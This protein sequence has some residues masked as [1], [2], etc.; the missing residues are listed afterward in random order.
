VTTTARVVRVAGPPLSGVTSLVAALRERMPETAFLEADE[1]AAAEP[2]AAVV[3]V[4]SAVAP[5][6]ESDCRRIDVATAQAA[7]V[8]GVLAKVDAHRGWRDVLAADRAALQARAA[9]YR[10]VPWVPVAA[11]PDLGPPELGGLVE[12]L[13]NR[14]CPNGL[15]ESGIGWLRAERAALVS[16]R[17]RA[18]SERALA[19]RGGLARARAA[20]GRFLRQRSMA[21]RAEFRVHAAELP[22]GGAAAVAAE[23]RGQLEGML[24]ELDVLLQAAIEEMAELAEPLELAVSAR[25]TPAGG[26]RLGD[27][28]GASRRGER[29]LTTVLGAGFGLGVA[30]AVSRLLGGLADELAGA[31][32]VVGALAGFA[33]TAWLVTTRAQ[34]AERARL[35]RW[36]TE[37]V[38]TARWHGEETIAGRLLGAE[39]EIA[40]ALSARE[41]AESSALAER[42]EAV[43]AEL[44]ALMRPAPESGTDCR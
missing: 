33:L 5:M 39:L 34:L 35:D 36:V 24:D 29:R 3:V 17:S 44:R 19:L 40:A 42:L 27:P 1:P 13:R 20:A 4:L 31:A 26:P 8:V 25:P 6:T 16:A 15:R 37:V 28:P 7:A 23:L 30:M 9:R 32:L 11:A 43:D 22:R 38:A 2:P 21:V 41:E 10:A 18:R 12:L 14:L